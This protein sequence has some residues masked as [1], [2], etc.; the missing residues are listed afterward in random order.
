MQQIQDKQM[1]AKQTT[2]NDLK[3][4]VES[5][6]SVG[7]KRAKLASKLMKTGWGAPPKP[8][9]TNLS[10]KVTQVKHL[11]AFHTTPKYFHCSSYRH[12]KYHTSGHLIFFGSLANPRIIMCTIYTTEQVTPIKFDSFIHSV[13]T[14]YLPTMCQAM[15]EVSGMQRWLRHKLSSQG[16]HCRMSWELQRQEN[17]LTPMAANEINS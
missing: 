13:N 6:G 17:I 15:S 9:T 2:T 1:F 3:R 5:P 12:Y 14:Y 8:Q 10:L 4:N 16:A 11:L 7:Y